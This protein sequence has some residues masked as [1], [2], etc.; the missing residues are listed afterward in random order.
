MWSN[1]V[2][3][4]QDFP[5]WSVYEGPSPQIGVC[6]CCLLGPPLPPQD[7]HVLCGPTPGVLQVHWKPPILSPTGM[8]NGVNVVGYAVCTKGQR[9]SS[10]VMTMSQTISTYLLDRWHEINLLGLP[11]VVVF[12][13]HKAAG[14]RVPGLWFLVVTIIA[15]HADIVL[16]PLKKQLPRQYFHFFMFCCFENR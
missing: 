14:V 15:L 7:V 6:L 2:K 5:D 10:Y 3:I 1:D 12:V 16:S 9:V 13:I 11:L 8:S 4:D